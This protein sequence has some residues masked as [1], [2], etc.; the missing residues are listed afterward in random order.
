[1]LTVPYLS[2]LHLW[3]WDGNMLRHCQRDET[4]IKT[5]YRAETTTAK[6]SLTV[7]FVLTGGGG[8]NRPGEIAVAPAPGPADDRV[9]PRRRDRTRAADKRHRGRGNID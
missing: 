6:S 1:M 5:T 2:F 4:C 8:C 9:A 7:P 3:T